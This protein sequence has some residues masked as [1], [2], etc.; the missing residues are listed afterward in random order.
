MAQTQAI[1]PTIIQA[2]DTTSWRRTLPACPADDGWTLSYRLINADSRLDVVASADGADHLVTLPAATTAAYPPGEYTWV[3]YAARGVERYTV[4]Q[5]QLRVRPDLAAATA[6]QDAR[7]DAQRALADLRA[8]LLRWLSSNGHVQEYEIA[9][10]RMRFASAA[11]IRQRI[12]LAESEVRR[13]AA[14]QGLAPAGARR[15]LVRF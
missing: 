11:D 7:T 9:G 1:E 15:V 6:P 12:A 5:G 3:A 8:A 4:A 13:E 10:R 2:G 14:A